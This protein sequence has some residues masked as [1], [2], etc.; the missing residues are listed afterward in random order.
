MRK[1]ALYR[2]R[3]VVSTLPSVVL[4]LVFLTERLVPVA[5]VLDPA[6]EARIKAMLQQQQA[7]LYE[8]GRHEG[9]PYESNI[10]VILKNPFNDGRDLLSI[11]GF[12][13]SDTCWDHLNASDADS[14]MD[15]SSEEFVTFA[16]LLV[17]DV[18][19]E[20]IDTY[21]ELPLVYKNVF[22]ATACLCQDELAGGDPNDDDCCQGDNA[23]IRIPVQP[24]LNP[25]ATEMNYLYTAC[26]L[27]EG[28]ADRYVV[29]DPPTMAPALVPVSPAPPTV[30]PVEAPLTD[31][32]VSE[33][34]QTAA[35]TSGAPLTAFPSV[36][37]DSVA[38]TTLAP[39][40]VPTA[41][42]SSLNGEPAVTAAPTPKGTAPVIVT[43]APVPAS[44]VP[45]FATNAP[46][47][48]AAETESP[49]V[50][51]TTSAPSQQPVIVE[52]VV[53]YEV[54]LRN[55]VV[56]MTNDNFV[57]E[58]LAN[59][60]AA[61][62]NLTVGV[63]DSGR[64]LQHG[65]L[66]L[67]GA[68]N[69]RRMAST[70]EVLLPTNIQDQNNVNCPFV[71]E[72]QL[73]NAT[74]CQ[75]IDASIRLSIPAVNNTDIVE[76]NFKDDVDKAI[77]SGALQGIL[78]DLEWDT[79]EGNP[80]IVLT[81]LN[82][83]PAPSPAPRSIESPSDTLSPVQIFG[84]S[85][86]SIAVAIIPIAIFLARRRQHDELPDDDKPA[87]KEYEAEDAPDDMATAGSRGAEPKTT[88]TAY[89][90]A[91]TATLGAAQAYYGGKGNDESGMLL[92]D[93]EDDDDDGAASSNAG[94]SG[95]S[96][97]AGIS[98]LNTGSV[99]D[100]GDIAAAAGATLAGLGVASA[101]SRNLRDTT[102]APRYVDNSCWSLALVC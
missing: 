60:I 30:A 89:D 25:N 48:I 15:I 88:D 26:S 42:P 79:V 75:K 58:Y 4:L 55:G 63:L 21:E 56:E 41:A 16:K 70:V 50:G 57:S 94:S 10:Q 62:D 44:V 83:V 8:A 12:V 24:G 33:A 87:Y 13:D 34:P 80:V 36:S 81:G 11:G 59:L 38:P 9:G 5:S 66:R 102:G 71:A 1:P 17:P 23:M 45:T 28:A 84:I 6:D 31:P 27:T 76:F 61:M 40:V 20:F 46:S 72:V 18:L 73:N 64:R 91:G 68:S 96:S 43:D 82:V 69:R 35:P 53:S 37:S 51:T 77:R 22:I 78:D 7:V 85:L 49:A 65:H 52:S 32:P 39:A 67:S 97:S 2:H 95:W 3:C 19:P 101:F 54:A 98:S 29:S 99:D 93:D 47:R 100:A 74:L 86:G 90:P 92:D 14:N